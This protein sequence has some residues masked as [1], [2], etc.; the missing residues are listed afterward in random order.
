MMT[1]YADRLRKFNRA[2]Q[3]QYE[4]FEELAD[5]IEKLEQDLAMA[6]SALKRIGDGD[7]SGKILPSMPPKDAAEFFAYQTYLAIKKEEE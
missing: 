5:H 4:W 3:V 2:G 6:K 1:N 7:F